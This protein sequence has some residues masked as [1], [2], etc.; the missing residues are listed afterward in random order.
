MQNMI[1]RYERNLKQLEKAREKSLKQL[2]AAKEKIQLK[3]EQKAMRKEKLARKW[4][5][6]AKMAMGY[7]FLSC[8]VVQIYSM[9]AMWHFADLSA[10][11]CLIG[12]TVGEV[13]AYCAYAAKSAKENTQGGIVHDMA[14]KSQEEN[15]KEVQG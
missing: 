2:E 13:G 15:T 12:A 10:L 14:V 4:P 3:E 7:I 11:Y 9:I 8:T 6:T 5:S 1:N